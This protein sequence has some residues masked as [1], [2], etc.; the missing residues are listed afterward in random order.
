MGTWLQQ[1][2]FIL[3]DYLDSGGVTM[4][5]LL[6]ACLVM[7][8]LIIDRLLFF[9]RLRCW[10]GSVEKESSSSPHQYGMQAVLVAECARDNR[11]WD[12]TKDQV[13]AVAGHYKQRLTAL[14]PVIGVLAATAPLLGLLGTVI[15]M[16]T[17]FDVLALF[18]TGNARAL[19]RGISE[20]LIT[21]QSGLLVA[22]PGFYMKSVLDHRAA[23]LK[24][25]LTLA[26]YW[27]KQQ[28]AQIGQEGSHD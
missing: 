17:T 24:Q 8:V 10:R 16:M 18:G 27:L 7:W 19:A 2:G 23:E 13:D 26:T 5:P 9:R 15:G 20:A 14:L 6:L 12:S 28:G 21:T 25:Q 4:V 11:K 1:Y 3:E 22:I